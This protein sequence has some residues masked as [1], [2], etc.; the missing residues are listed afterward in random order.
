MEV[1]HMAPLHWW[2]VVETL[3]EEIYDEQA[4]EWVVE[5]VRKFET[6]E[7]CRVFVATE[8]SRVAG[9]VV[10]QWLDRSG[11]ADIV[12]VPLMALHGDEQGKHVFLFRDL[13][14]RAVR[15]WE[16]ETHDKVFRL[17]FE[18][19]GY[20]EEFAELLPSLLTRMGLR[21]DRH[22]L[23]GAWPEKGQEGNQ[24]VFNV[25]LPKGR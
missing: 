13:V 18:V 14:L 8:G 10:L 5:L 6:D 4:L 20:N 15:A 21:F 24:Y 3:H 12:R 9:V 2:K 19:D 17:V 16:R 11:D 23:V 1:H 25:W 7:L 22:D